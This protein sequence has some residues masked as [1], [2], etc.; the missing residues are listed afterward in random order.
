[1]ELQELVDRIYTEGHRHA[2]VVG[3]K[4]NSVLPTKMHRAEVA[5]MITQYYT[6]RQLT[7]FQ[8]IALGILRVDTAT[9]P[10]T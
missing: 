9:A 7:V 3:S 4:A 8:L 10:A 6:R 1:M 5:Q 2:T